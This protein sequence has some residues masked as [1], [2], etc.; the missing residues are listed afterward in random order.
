MAAAI[1]D[2][3]QNKARQVRRWRTSNMAISG[4]EKR[5]RTRLSFREIVVPCSLL[6]ITRLVV[7]ASNFTS[8]ANHALSNELGR[9]LTLFSDDHACYIK[10]RQRKHGITR[11]CNLVL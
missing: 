4:G 9:G 5:R 3:K 10:A 1:I 11:F 6:T 8:L 7:R 2:V